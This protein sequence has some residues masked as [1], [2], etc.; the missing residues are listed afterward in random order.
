M[1]RSRMLA[2]LVG[3][4]FCVAVM[5]LYR[6]LDL[7]QG[8]ESKRYGEPPGGQVD[9]DLAH[10]Q[11]KIDGLE[12]LLS[13][14][15]RLVAM[16][17]DTLLQ[18]KASAWKRANNSIDSALGRRGEA[19]PGCRLAKEM[20]DGVDGVQL[21]DVYDLL[22]FD[23][24]DGGPWKQ[25]FEITYK[26]DEWS[27]QP[28]ELFLIPHSHNDPGWIKTFDAYYHDQTRHILDNMVVKLSE[29]NRRKLIWAE[30]SYFSKWWN[31]IDDQKRAAVKRLVEA[32]QLELVT[33]GWVMPD[34]ANSHYFAML[35]QLMEGHQWLQKHLGVKPRSGWAIDPF[36]HSPSMAYLLKGAGLHNMLIQRV[37]YSIKKHFAQQQTLE[38]LWRQSWDSSSRSDITCHMMPFYSYDVPHT[39][40][41]NPAVCCQFDFQRLPGRRTFCPWKIPPK[42]ITD[43]N[44]HERALLLLD[45]YR[46]K[47]RLFRSSVLLVPL[48]D[49]FRYVESSE[50][51][52]QFNNYQKLFDYF[53][54]HPELHIKARFGTLSDYFQALHRRL[55]TTR[56]TLPKLRGDFFSYADRDDHYWTGYFTSRPFYK[57][58]DRKLE[59]TLRAT[60]I[61]F[62]LTLAEMRRSHSDGRLAENFPAREY[63]Q[64]LTTGRRN[65]A[66]FQHHDAVAGTEREHVVVDY[67]TR[68]FQS[69]LNL[70]QVLQSSAHWL[71]LLDKSQYHHD[72]SKSLIIFNPTEQLRTSVI[73]VVV[74]S[75]DAQVIDAE[76]G[77]QMSTQISAVWAEP[78]RPS[79]DTFQVR[80]SSLIRLLITAVCFNFL[81]SHS[82]SPSWLNFLLCHSSCTIILLTCFY[83]EIQKLR[84]QSGLVRKIQ[85]Q[86]LW[87]GTRTGSRDKSGA[88][89]FLPADEGLYISSEPPLVRISRG[90][91]FSDIT[92]HFPHFTHTVR[93]FHLDGHAGKS[94]EISNLV[95]I[96]SQVNRELV[97][98]IVSDVA[99][100][101]RFYSDLNGFQMQQRRTLAKL[102]LQANFYPMTSAV[103]LQDSTSRLSLL[104]AQSQGVASLKPGELELVLDRRLQQDDNRGLGQGVTDNKLTASLYHLLLED[105]GGGAKICRWGLV[106]RHIDHLSLLAHLA[107][108]SLCHPPMTM[109]A[110]SNSQLLKLR[111][112]Q[113]LHSSLPCDIHL[114]NLRT[115]EDTQEA[116]TPS[117]ETALFLHRKGFD[118]STAPEPAPQCTWSEHEEVM[119]RS[120]FI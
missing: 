77:R 39:C 36:G 17:R 94:L 54:Q 7:M 51:D 24:P 67:G 80:T 52:V 111:P 59:A 32:G 15:N 61:L 95:D 53:N 55:S 68:L 113:P 84:L 49:D 85:V 78:S 21:L 104:S 87:Y 114:L 5:S 65:L 112:F 31:D 70:H 45:Q 19:L 105:R 12:R 102:P 97:M 8:S 96:R 88:Y 58:L 16:L 1:K 86:F 18:S 56:T 2:V 4:I 42:P 40:G 50:W 25:G 101:N 109:V 63:F 57:R 79:T 72:Q 44:V 89:L 99:S 108:L 38:F 66:L 23:N 103:F 71:L 14:N 6:M 91:I 11:Q 48:G 26:G 35:D 93:L 117:Q 118:C 115:L 37:H 33:G 30:I 43:Q 62:S 13:D 69:I 29:D 73:S 22:P 98:K 106:S 76:T 116:D 81:F 28:L 119:T 107:S 82:S 100:G 3:G 75:P 120:P 64:W 47:S 27:E 9:E 74:D 92:S 83:F 20:K 60:E 110:T 41:P 34:E 46:Q 90:P 10:L